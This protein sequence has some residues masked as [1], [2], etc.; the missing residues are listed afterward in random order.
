MATIEQMR[1]LATDDGWVLFAL[2]QWD[3]TDEQILRAIEASI[4]VNG[5]PK[6]TKPDRLRTGEWHKLPDGTPI[7]PWSYRLNLKDRRSDVDES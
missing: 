4:V 1:E 6:G 7:R 2:N 3:R 5:W